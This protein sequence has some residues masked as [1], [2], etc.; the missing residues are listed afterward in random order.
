M[1]QAYEAQIERIT[2]DG[3]DLPTDGDRLHLKR[4]PGQDQRQPVP[5]EPGMSKHRKTVGISPHSMGTAAPKSVT[6][7][8]SIASPPARKG[9]ASTATIRIRRKDVP[10]SGTS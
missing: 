10:T 8:T 5:G 3:I 7:P 2:G 4:K 6:M 1:R 9:S